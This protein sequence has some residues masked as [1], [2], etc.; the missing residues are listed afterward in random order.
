M[1]AC[2]IY[3][4][5]LAASGL[6]P[7]LGRSGGDVTTAQH[8]RAEAWLDRHGWLAIDPAD[9]R[10]VVLEQ[11]LP[12]NSPPIAALADTLFGGAEG[13]WAG[14]NSVPRIAL[15]GAPQQPAFRFLM[16]PTAMTPSRV[17]DSVDP[18]NF[19]YRIS[20]REVGV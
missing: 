1:P 8:C 18:A 2:E 13:N 5:R 19:A 6:W 17:I 16:Y 10:K 4:V 15:K 12:A 20:S 3:G 11:K 14:Y 7:S 9:V